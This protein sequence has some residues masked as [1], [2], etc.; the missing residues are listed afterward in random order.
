WRVTR[1]I[2]GHHREDYARV[3]VPEARPSATPISNEE[4]VLPVSYV[5]KSKTPRYKSYSVMVEER[6][7]L[8]PRAIWSQTCIF[9]HNTVPYESTVLGALAGSNAPA[10][11]GEVVDALLPDAKRASFVVKD[12]DALARDLAAEEARIGASRDKHATPRSAITATRNHF[13]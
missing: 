9:C 1:V 4:L 3:S 11:Q 7:R 13:R 12:E 2:G 8:K 5:F 6:A 10:Y